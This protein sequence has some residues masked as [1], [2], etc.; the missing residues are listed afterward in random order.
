MMAAE[1]VAAEVVAAEVVRAEVDPAALRW[2]GT[3]AATGGPMAERN[4]TSVDVSVYVKADDPHSADRVFRAVD[5]L[6][7]IVGDAERG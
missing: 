3:I 5:A 7:R 2:A 6:A 1:V 4:E